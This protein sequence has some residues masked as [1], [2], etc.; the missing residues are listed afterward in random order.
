MSAAEAG[1][2]A[3]GAETLPEPQDA[4]DVRV[5][6]SVPREREE[7]ADRALG[8]ARVR[9][10][11]EVGA[12][13]SRAAGPL[14][15]GRGAHDRQRVGDRDTTEPE[16]AEPRVGLRLERGAE[17]RAVERVVHHHAGDAG[18]DRGSKRRE[19]P[20]PYPRIDVW[21]LVCG[22]RGGAEAWKVLGA[23]S[24]A[25]AAREGDPDRTARVLP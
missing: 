8:V 3:A 20:W 6:L 22:I 23:G 14:L 17:R 7:T 11:P 9:D 24:V 1:S 15:D 25:E 4:H 12:G 21:P 2:S 18:A 19:V 16:R 10:E 5:E 13:A